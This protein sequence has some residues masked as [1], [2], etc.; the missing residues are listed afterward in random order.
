MSGDLAAALT[1]S[2]SVSCAA[3]AI[4]IGLGVRRRRDRVLRDEWIAFAKS[5]GFQFADKTGPWYRRRGP[6]ITGSI[7]GVT[8]ALAK[9]RVHRGKHSIEYTRVRGELARPVRSKLVVVARDWARKLRFGFGPSVVQT[10]H[11]QFD[12]KAIVRSRVRAEPMALL[13]ADM[14]SRIVAFPRKLQI[15]CADRAATIS[16][17]AAERDPAVLGAACE[18]LAAL[19]RP[20]R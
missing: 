16:W 18:M 19:C 15:V 4:A 12:E 1:V 2:L 14:R 10:G 17:R 3:I 13:D 11:T 8:F 6:T 20:R 7:D 9:E 5:H